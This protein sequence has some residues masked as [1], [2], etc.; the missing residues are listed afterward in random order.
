MRSFGGTSTDR[1]CLQ[2]DGTWVMY[3]SALHYEQKRRHC[4]GAATSPNIAGPYVPVN[5]T[6]ACDFE[7][8]GAIDPAYFR[9][10]VSKDSHLIYKDDGNAIGSGG[11]CSNANMPNTPT[12]LRSQKLDPYDLVTPIG[13][14]IYLLDNF[15]S[16]GPDIE[17]PQMWYV[18]SPSP[19][20]HLVYNSG[21]YHDETYK[22]KHIICLAGPPAGT[23]FDL[24]SWQLSESLQL[25]LGDDSQEWRI[26]NLSKTGDL[27][28]PDQKDSKVFAPGGAAVEPKGRA[29]A[30][31]A[32][33]N[34]NFFKNPANETRVRGMFITILG[35]E[36]VEDGLQ[37]GKLQFQNP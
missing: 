37:M 8:G 23:T 18:D 25:Y 30:F 33:L 9:D 16:D 14:A 26:G 13:P 11:E 3:Y 17:A 5:S 27:L 32:D 35:Y 2:T 19:Q 12:P 6:L 29:M 24:C 22:L 31:H 10:P 28:V 34:L 36:W 1:S 20:Y 7:K 15:P 21:C 4:I